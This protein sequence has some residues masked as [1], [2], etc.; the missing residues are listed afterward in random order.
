MPTKQAVAH[1]NANA[2]A[3]LVASATADEWESRDG[4]LTIIEHEDS[5]TVY[6][7]AKEDGALILD[8]YYTSGS[9]ERAELEDG[10]D[11]MEVMD[12]LAEWYAS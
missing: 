5:N 4:S 8:C 12:W 3:N 7:S 1:A 10:T 6:I 2:A 11:T 9:Y